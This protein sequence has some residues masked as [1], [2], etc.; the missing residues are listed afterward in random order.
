[1]KMSNTMCLGS[2][3]IF[4]SNITETLILSRVSLTESQ[5]W[6]GNWIYWIVTSCNYK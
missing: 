6:I 5:V 4:S 1:M 3:Y 2:C